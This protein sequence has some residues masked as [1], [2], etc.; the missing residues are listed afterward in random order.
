MSEFWPIVTRFVRKIG[1]CGHTGR[2]WDKVAG[3]RGNEARSILHVDL[4]VLS[5]ARTR[6][7]LSDDGFV[8]QRPA[9][10]VRR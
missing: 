9:A 4:L 6:V 10:G 3:R 1:K 8:L 2:Y 5:P 7:N